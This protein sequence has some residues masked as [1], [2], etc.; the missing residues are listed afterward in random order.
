MKYTKGARAFLAVIFLGNV[1]SIG[2]VICWVLR[3]F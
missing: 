2:Y 3:E 1:L